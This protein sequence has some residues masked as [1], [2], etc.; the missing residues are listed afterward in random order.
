MES[1]FKLNQVV[2]VKLK[3]FP[4]WPGIVSP[5]QSFLIIDK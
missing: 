4:W 1:N 3:G 2:W 5:Y